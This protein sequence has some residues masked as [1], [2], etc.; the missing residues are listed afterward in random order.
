MTAISFAVNLCERLPCRT[1]FRIDS[2]D[3][4]AIRRTVERSVSDLVREAMHRIVDAKGFGPPGVQDGQFWLRELA[5]RLTS[6]QA[7]IER[8]QWC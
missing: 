7:E 8:L 1:T 2:V 6:L 5:G 3:S 4:L